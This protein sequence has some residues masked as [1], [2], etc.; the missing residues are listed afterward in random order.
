M[1][2]AIPARRA[3]SYIIAE[4]SPRLAAGMLAAVID[5]DGIH[6]AFG[7]FISYWKL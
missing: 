4:A 6:M 5:V 7:F 1:L 3:F 2:E